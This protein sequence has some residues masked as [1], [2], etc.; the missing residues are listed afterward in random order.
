VR[1]GSRPRATLLLSVHSTAHGG[2]ERCAVAEAEHLWPSYSLIVAAPAGPLLDDLARH[3]TIVGGP[4]LLP[5]WGDTPRRWTV[6][7]ART[8]V[9]TFRLVRLIRR[10]RV[11]AV[12]CNSSVALSPI[13]AARLTR[14]PVLVHLRDSP[15]SRLAPAL[16][17]LIARI[18]TTVVPVSPGLAALC[19]ASPRAR[20]VPIPDGI[21]IPPPRRRPPPRD[22]L[23][24][25]VVGAIDRGKGQDLAVRALAE[26]L[27]AG[28][29]AELQLVGREQDKA[30]AAELRTTARECGVADRVHFHGERRDLERVYAGLDVLLLPSRREAFGLVVLEAL[31]R[32]LPVVAV[33]VGC[34]PELLLAGAAGVIVQP[35]S[36]PALAAGI[37]RLK[38]DPELVRSLTSRGRNHAVENYDVKT[39][40]R[41][42]GE[43]IARMIGDPV[44]SRSPS[45]QLAERELLSGP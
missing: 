23:Q 1:A 38:A 21:P 34:V 6:Q 19:G 28:M 36:P 37:A 39:A 26:V 29:D 32:S 12:V 17:R 31:A 7:L 45:D 20:V 25:G 33:R 5:I 13:L 27:G 35:E 44:P 16:V 15:N 3:G 22:P 18:A 9:D 4:P 30:F 14:R 43:E 40:L 8:L 42:G 24:L 11:D 2:S 10:E 41:L